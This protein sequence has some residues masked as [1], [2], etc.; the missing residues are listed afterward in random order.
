LDGFRYRSY[1]RNV[2]KIKVTRKLCSGSLDELVSLINFFSIIFRERDVF[3][4]DRK[5]KIAN[6]DVLQYALENGMIDLA[7]VREQIEMN[8]RKEVLEKHPYSIWEGKNGYW[9]TYIFDPDKK[10]SRRLIKYKTR[11]SLEDKLVQ[12]YS[13]HEVK[14]RER[15]LETIYPE[16]LQY[17][18]MHT[19]KS[20]SVKRYTSEW[21]RYYKNDAI[22]KYPIKQLD[23]LIL[24]EWVHKMIKAYNMTKKQ[25]YTM[26]YIL[27]HCMIYAEEKGYINQNVFSSIKIES[28]MFRKEQKK[29]DETQVYLDSEQPM[30][31]EEAWRDYNKNPDNT[32]PLAV[33]LL[34]YLGARPG[35]I[36][37][38][39]EEDVKEDYI[40]I[41]RM[42][43]GDFIEIEPGKYKR[44]S[45]SV[46]EHTKTDAGDRLVPLIGKAVKIVG[47][48]KSVNKR[49]N[50]NGKY[51]FMNQGERIKE[52]AISWRLEKYCNHLQIPYRSPH[53][54]RKTVISS[55]IDANVNINTIRK[56]VGH[57]DEKTTYN[58]YCFDRKSKTEIK[59]QLEIALDVEDHKKN[60]VQ[61]NRFN[62]EP[63]IMSN[64][65]KVV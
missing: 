37:A 48:I 45:R 47:L 31:I 46:V 27:R 53:K 8:K 3:K 58:N 16:W 43:T 25:Y 61:F 18:S 36:V 26:S 6:N 56:I 29:S 51:L 52:T 17:F 30:I 32:T 33:I 14:E 9:Y 19:N 13:D 57:E 60:V 65:N 23:K 5:D 22:I 34:F 44:I 4:I 49:L 40:H 24:D 54:V 50:C 38:I 21:A 64:H 63:V 11:K 15:T 7:Y 59:R 20:A 12:Y 28:K 41:R 42:E 39:K 1:K 2:V 10:N 35:E 62:S 55:M